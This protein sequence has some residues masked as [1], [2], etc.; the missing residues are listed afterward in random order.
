MSHVIVPLRANQCGIL[1]QS[2]L[3]A[4]S[5]H[6]FILFS[7]CQ[8]VS[9][10]DSLVKAQKALDRYSLQGHG[11]IVLFGMHKTRGTWGCFKKACGEG[12]RVGSHVTRLYHTKTRWSRLRKHWT[13]T[14]YKGMATFFFLA[15]KKHAVH[16]DAPK[17][18]VE[19]GDVSDL[20]LPGC[21][22]PSLVGLGSESIG[23]VLAIWAW[24]CF[25]F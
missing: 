23:Q 20:T 13:G 12:R 1:P 19:R 22:T 3:A 7:R 10:Q 21:I 5:V 8:V 16:G 18:K 15:C 2:R 11:N 6:Y 25:S 24:Q 14:R 9:H 17:R 4:P